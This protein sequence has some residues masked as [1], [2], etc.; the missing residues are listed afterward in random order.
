MKKIIKISLAIITFTMLIY[1]CTNENEGVKEIDSVFEITK[2]TN[3]KTI[4]NVTNFLNQKR[5]YKKGGSDFDFTTM[6]KIYNTET[7]DVS[8]VVNSFSNENIKLGVYPKSEDDYALFIIE[9]SVTDNLK[10]VIYRNMNN[11]LL[12]ELL[13]NLDDGS[14]TVVKSSNLQ[15]KCDGTDVMGCVDTNYNKNGWW[16][17]AGYAITL[18]QPWF[19]AA[20]LASCAAYVC[21]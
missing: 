14:M 16:G 21:L 7:N 8:Y 5:G 4:N 1:S 20:V 6:S 2:V 18:A 3:E 12:A 13:F 19:G 11:N 9:E 17:V 15:S 10:T